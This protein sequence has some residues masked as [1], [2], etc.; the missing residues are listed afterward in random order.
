MGQYAWMAYHV[1]GYRSTRLPLIAQTLIYACAGAVYLG[2]TFR[3]HEGHR[4]HVFVTWYCISGIEGVLGLL[5]SNYSPILSLGK[6]HLMKRLTL[7]TVMIL[8]EGI[9]SIANKVLVIV[10]HK[11]A[12]D[13]T[14]IGLVTAAAATVYFVFLVYFD[15]LG[16]KTHLPHFRRNFWVALHFPFH[17]ALVLFMQGFTQM[18]IWGKIA[19]QLRRAF[20][21]A[22]PSDDLNLVGDSTTTQEVF[23]AMNETVQGFLKDYPSKLES[24]SEVINLALKNISSLPD[25]FWPTLAKVTT[26]DAENSLGSL[27]GTD[28]TNLEKLYYSVGSIAASLANNVFQAFNTEV[29]GEIVAKNKALE[30]ADGRGFQFQVQ[31]ESWK[32][33]GLVVCTVYSQWQYATNTNSLPTHI[34]VQPALFF[35]FLS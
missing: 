34:L 26:D 35:S 1:R 10:K 32:R 2:I 28:E 33:Y 25:K 5:L 31:D 21:S 8:G 4:S 15:W 29:L 19:R 7:L 13:G 3:F 24:T 16:T 12:W 18:L 27:N 17:L 14:T 30:K 20:D 23:N 6:T 11:P 9:E 22:D